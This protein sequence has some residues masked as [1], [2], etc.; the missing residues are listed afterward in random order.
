MKLL[1]NTFYIISFLLIP[2]SAQK[3]GILP[4]ENLSGFEEVWDIRK[5]IP[6]HFGAMLAKEENNEIVPFDEL[7]ALLQSNTKKKINQYDT[8][9]WKALLPGCDVIVI[10][11]IDQ[12]D[13][14]RYNVAEPTLAGYEYYSFTVKMRVIFA[15][16]NLGRVS[17]QTE[18]ETELSRNVVGL[19]LFGRTSS[20][21]K[22][23]F[24]LSQIDF[25]S[26]KFMRSI[27]G[28]G[29]ADAFNQFY[30][31]YKREIKLSY[32]ESDDESESVPTLTGTL[33]TYDASTGDAFVNIITKGLKPGERLF[34]YE[35]TDSLYDQ[36]TGELI[37]IAE[38][39][40]GELR[41][42]EIRNSKLLYAAVQGD[43][44][45]LR[46]G[47]IIKYFRKP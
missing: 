24:G 28:E 45:V 26:E 32:S 17:E 1:R 20:D 2:L 23:F 33:L 35:E 44:T 5:D 41:I 25:G 39:R 46:P 10:G 29:M 40:I 27:V 21:R 9:D 7:D 47:L 12:F 8:E 38:K 30:K 18:V 6:V 31:H 13:L 11:Y 14:K 19:N 3:V 34:V 16:L 37:G 43:K 4:F 22:D 36:N 15:D 42:L